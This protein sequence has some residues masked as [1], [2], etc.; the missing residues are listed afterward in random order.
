VS[1]LP[2]T[3]CLAFYLHPTF[4]F[5]MSLDR[6][7]VVFIITGS[8]IYSSTPRSH[9]CTLQIIGVRCYTDSEIPQLRQVVLLFY[10]KCRVASCPP[11]YFVCCSE[12]GIPCPQEMIQ[13]N[14]AMHNSDT[15]PGYSLSRL[16][17]DMFESSVCY[18]KVAPKLKQPEFLS[19]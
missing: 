13:T 18:S 7:A 15:P 1:R 12:P 17:S 11:Y 16:L 3:F 2:H 8:C 6:R 9:L 14:S 4:R 5:I 19:G 10:R